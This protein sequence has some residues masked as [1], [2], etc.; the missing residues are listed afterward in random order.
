MQELEAPNR[1]SITDTLR[2]ALSEVQFAYVFG[3]FLQRS[4][5]AESDID[6]AVE[7]GEPLGWDAV[8]S[9]QRSSNRALVTKWTLSTCTLPI[10]SSE[11][12]YSDTV[13]C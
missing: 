2:K 8:W 6:L 12:R 4:F 11:C 3:S 10:R 7:L 9:W 13:S 1:E 5:T